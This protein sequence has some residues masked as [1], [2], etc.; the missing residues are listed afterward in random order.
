[1]WRR[2]GP[3][4][5]SDKESPWRSSRMSTIAKT[6]RGPTGAFVKVGR[7]IMPERG[8]RLAMA[9]L[10]AAVL[11][12]AVG[13]ALY[14][15]DL[16]GSHNLA[17]P[18]P[19]S[20]PH[21]ANAAG[22]GSVACVGCHEPAHGVT[23]LRCER[24]HDPI[25]ARRFEGPAHAR[26]SGRVVPAA[27]AADVPCASC[28][29]EHGGLTRD[30]LR[31]AGDETCVSCHAFTSFKRHPEFAA[32]RAR[33]QEDPGIK[34]QHDVHLREVAKTGGDR[35]R[36]CHT[37]TSD[38]VGFLPIAFDAH[39][40]RCH[41]KGGVLTTNGNDVLL[42]N[43]SAIPTQL[44]MPES[45]LAL[46]GPAVPA[47][48]PNG[49]ALCVAGKGTVR[50][51]DSVN[52][53][54]FRHR[55]PWALAV[56]ARLAP[57][58]AG[59]SLAAEQANL[60]DDVARLS[61]V[62]KSN[63]IASLTNEQLG[64][65]ATAVA[66][67]RAAIAGQVN[68]GPSAAG[69]AAAAVGAL[70]TSVD[71]SL[72]GV[73]DAVG[74]AP[75]QPGAGAAKSASGADV[76]ARRQELQQ[77]VDAIATRTDGALAARAADLKKRLGDV[78]AA[79]QTAATVDARA[80]HERL[81]ALADVIGTVQREAGDAA[82]GDLRATVSEVERQFGGMG[83]ATDAALRAQALALLDRAESR[84]TPAAAAR[85]A[86]LRIALALGPGGDLRS[87]QDQVDRLLERISLERSLRAAG[88]VS[89]TDA[90][91]TYE[92]NA[93][94]ESLRAV[95]A[96]LAAARRGA[97]APATGLDPAKAKAALKG[98]VGAC[99]YCHQLNP[100]GSGFRAVTA[101]RSVLQPATFTHAAHQQDCESCHRSVTTSKDAL[102]SNLPG[103]A[104]CQSCHNA[105]QAPS[106]CVSC[107][108]YHPRSAAEMVVAEAR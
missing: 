48:S 10:A 3:G 70:A 60:M 73:A 58:V 53:T 88:Q 43:G 39:C 24:C 33:H 31:R 37:P 57:A 90:R 96:R 80:M 52:L 107:H 55:D 79:D 44:S 56:A 27:H 36:A 19:L 13:G 66:T 64:A 61:A 38:R 84:A 23:E 30:Q 92:R 41:L 25:D 14:G 42:S 15:F 18:G 77:L 68:A 35:C 59:P 72:A 98:V 87:R 102:E 45:I 78:K 62:S 7:Y 101:G 67:E 9:S 97:G 106:D 22:G 4:T 16:L 83:G 74:R 50:G 29:R 47:C 93:A 108:Q 8:G 76:D 28:H 54:N 82:A 105:S 65:L 46:E 40:A 34:F 91:I 11:L 71:P 89:A 17:S 51:V 95:D 75:A 2:I 81:A 104:S 86:E 1:M 12:L 21:A 69:S 49:S 99:T 100:D 6:N 5:R 85:I 94:L 63:G 32:V 26:S 103:V 20:S